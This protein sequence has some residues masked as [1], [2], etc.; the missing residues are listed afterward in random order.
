MK[1]V[2]VAANLGVIAEHFSE[3]EG[4]RI[5][6]FDGTTIHVVDYLEND[7]A[8]KGKLPEQLNLLEV[9]EIIAGGIGAGQ[10]EKLTKAGIQVISGL[11]G[12]VSEAILHYH[13]GE[14][15]ENKAAGSCGSSCGCG[16]QGQELSCGCGSSGEVSACGCGGCK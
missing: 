12:D 1:R 9:G 7:S 2:A 14:I 13:R 15:L 3:A 4:F 16:S 5:Y 11:S 6:E 8:L 10:M